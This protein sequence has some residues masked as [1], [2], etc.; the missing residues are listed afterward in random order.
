VTGWRDPA[1][2]V[3]AAKRFP[4]DEAYLRDLIQE[5]LDEGVPSVAYLKT[6]PNPT[7]AEELLI[8]TETDP[9]GMLVAARDSGL[10]GLL[11]D[12]AQRLG[13][14]IVDLSFKSSRSPCPLARRAVG[15][16]MGN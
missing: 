6:N 4:I 5:L 2:V 15:V 8:S 16:P 9:G 7:D 12:Q 10:R 1:K 14:G 13:D 3:G 11:Y